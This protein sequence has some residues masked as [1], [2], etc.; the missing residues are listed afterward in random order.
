LLLRGISLRSLLQILLSVISSSSIIVSIVVGARV[1]VTVI[2]AVHL[3]QQLRNEVV[4][5][6]DHLLLLI[7]ASMT[8]LNLS[9]SLHQC[10]VYIHGQL[11][12]L[13]QSSSWVIAHLI[14][15]N[16]WVIHLLKQKVVVLGM[17]KKSRLLVMKNHQCLMSSIMDACLE[18]GSRCGGV[19]HPT[20]TALSSASGLLIEDHVH[21]PLMALAAQWGLLVNVERLSVVVQGVEQWPLRK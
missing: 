15:T 21:L 8:L 17:M 14:V 18:G 5:V 3:C 9:R 2:L 10:M 19:V 11:H 1:G 16:V 12:Q 4:A 20:N 13:S 6:F 7:I